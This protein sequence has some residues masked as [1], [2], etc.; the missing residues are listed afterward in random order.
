[1]VRFILF[2]L[3][4]L[5]GM[6]AAVATDSASAQQLPPIATGVSVQ[7]RRTLYVNAFFAEAGEQIQSGL[8]WRGF[9][10]HKDAN[11]APPPIA[12]S[13][14]AGPGLLLQTG[15]YAGPRFFGVPPPAER[16]G[17]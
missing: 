8:K 2:R 17:N 12:E 1:M 10:A 7:G 6:A 5:A 14:P 4:A 11:G 9:R 3:L 13:S 15:T 16:L